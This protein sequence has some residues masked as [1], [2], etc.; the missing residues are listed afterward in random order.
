MASIRPNKTF[1]QY[2]SIYYTVGKL[3]VRIFPLDVSR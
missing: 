1:L 2:P 3:F